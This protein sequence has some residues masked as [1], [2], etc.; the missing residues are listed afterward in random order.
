LKDARACDEIDLNTPNSFKP[1]P[2]VWRS[3]LTFFTTPNLSTCIGIV[4][5]DRQSPSGL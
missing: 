3:W 1:N 2:G 4:I 5:D